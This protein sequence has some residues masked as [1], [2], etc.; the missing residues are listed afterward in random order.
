MHFI[1]CD[2]ECF[3]GNI[4]K[5]IAFAT[6]FYCLGFSFQPPISFVE[7]T[8][9]KQKENCWLTRNLHGI[10]WE[11]GTYPFSYVETILKN[12]VHDNTTVFVRGSQKITCLESYLPGTNFVDLE[13]LLCPKYTD[14]VRYPEYCNI[15]SCYLYPQHHNSALYLGHCAIKKASIYLRWVMEKNP[16]TLLNTYYNN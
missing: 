15:V 1:I 14:L 3:Q 11:S 8:V 9:Q 10:T 12:F 5:E 16:E 7:L 6:Q 2:I 13:H 4:I